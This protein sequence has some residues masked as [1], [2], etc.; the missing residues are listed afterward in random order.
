MSR[1]ARDHP[2]DSELEALRGPD[3]VVNAAFSSGGVA[4]VVSMTM[5]T[6]AEYTPRR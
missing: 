3:G 1:A 2:G 4:S 6:I 5:A